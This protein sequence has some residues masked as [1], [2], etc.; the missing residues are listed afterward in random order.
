MEKMFGWKIEKW[1]GSEA[2]PEG[3][4]YWVVTTVDDKGNE[5]LTGGMMKRQVPQ[6]IKT[7]QQGITNHFDLKF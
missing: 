6:G 5:A 3:M 1:P 4:E 7:Y 2:M